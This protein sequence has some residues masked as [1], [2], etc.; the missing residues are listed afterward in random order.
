MQNRDLAVILYTPHKVNKVHR[1]GG[2]ELYGEPK[3]L[4]CPGGKV[5]ILNRDA[6]VLLEFIAASKTPRQFEK[7][8][9]QYQQGCFIKAKPGTIRFKNGPQ[10]SGNFHGD[11]SFR[12]LEIGSDHM[13]IETD[14]GYDESPV[15]AKKRSNEKIHQTPFSGNIQGLER[16]NPEARLVRQY[17]KYI[18]NPVRFVQHHY[19]NLHCDLFDTQQSRLIEAKM[20]ISRETIRMAYGQLCDY[21]RFYKKPQYKCRPR[22]AILLPGKPDRRVLRFLTDYKTLVI[23]KQ[24]GCSLKFTDSAGGHWTRASN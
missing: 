5:R 12:F 20:N 19:Q 1:E 2:I 14:G 8:N 7:S 16:D 10:I 17:V 3:S 22:L 18:G 21:R 15:V 11:G 4:K 6:R 23:W 9:G 24:F 13:T